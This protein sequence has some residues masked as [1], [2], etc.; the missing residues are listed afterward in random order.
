[1]ETKICKKCGIEKSIEK[2]RKWNKYYRSECKECEKNRS[3]EYKTQHK[4]EIE[5]YRK[6]YREKNKDLLRLKQ[7]EYAK[8]YY[9]ENKEIVKQKSNKYYHENKEK[10]RKC[11]ENYKKNN[12]EKIKAHR[13]E[14]DNKNKEKLN[15]Y[16]RKYIFDKRNNNKQF[17]LE[18]QIRHMLNMAFNRK[19]KR[20]SKRLETIVSC[21]IN[22]LV[23]YLIKTYENNYNEKWDWNC[24]KDIHID[25][26]I[27]L[28]SANTEEDII[29]LNHYTNLQLLKAKDN[30]E[31]SDKLDWK[32]EV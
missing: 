13:K 6:E 31:K 1:M 11:Q 5:K 22:E 3:Y 26:I 7:R 15:E 12:F 14:Y 2:F 19:N 17:K 27:P 29:K 10:A 16:K 21:S 25:H 4:K 20:K 8:K 28:A 18:C 24:L 32:L 30:L 9:Q 23:I